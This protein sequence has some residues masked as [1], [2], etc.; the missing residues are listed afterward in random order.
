[1]TFE[2]ILPELKNGATITRRSYSDGVAIKIASDGVIRFT[3]MTNFMIDD[4]SAYCMDWNNDD[5]LAEDWEV[6]KELTVCN[7]YQEGHWYIPEC[8]TCLGTKEKEPCRCGGNKNR[9]D[10]YKN[11]I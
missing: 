9:C 11:K 6:V 2:K 4:T 1:M 7:C 10:F 3:S 5:I 8:G